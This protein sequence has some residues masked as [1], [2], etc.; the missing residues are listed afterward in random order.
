MFVMEGQLRA[1]RIV[2]VEHT[3]REGEHQPAAMY[4]LQLTGGSRLRIRRRRNQFALAGQD[5][6]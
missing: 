5:A 2:M 6:C 3:V 4:T 1:A